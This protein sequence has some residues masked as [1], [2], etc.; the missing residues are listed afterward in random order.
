MYCWLSGPNGPSSK[1]FISERKQASEIG[2]ERQE[3]KSKKSNLG[4]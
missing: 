2:L 3:I 1:V 4:N